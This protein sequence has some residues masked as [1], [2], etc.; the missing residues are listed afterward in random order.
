MRLNPFYLV[1]R[2]FLLAALFVGAACP[3]SAQTL[4]SLPG[5]VPQA[6]SR[7]TDV[8]DVPSTNRLSLALGLPVR[9]EPGLDKFLGELHDPASPNFRRYLTTEEFTARFG[10]TEKQYNEVIQFAR[11]HNLRVTGTHA[12]RLVLDVEGSAADVQR[13]F[14]ISLKNWQHPREGRKF[15]APVGEPVLDVGLPIARISGLDNYAMRRPKLVRKPQAVS[16]TV[17]P[18][19]GSSPNGSFMGYDFRKA[20]VPGTALTGAGQKVALLQFDTYYTNDVVAYEN[21]AGLPRVPLKNV[22]VNGGVSTPG[23]GNVEVCLDIEM[24]ISMAPGLDQVIVYIA[25]DITPW[26][27]ILSRIA[28]DNLAKQVSCSWGDTSPGSIDSSSE[29]ALKQMAAQGQ[30]FFNATGDDCAFT[31]SGIPFPSESTNV[32]Q[33]GGTTLTMSGSGNNYSSE[34]VWNWGGGTGSG[35]GVSINFS[36]PAWQQGT[37]NSTNLGSTSKRNVPDV[38]LTADDIFTISDNGTRS[39][40]GGTSAAAPLW[41][42]FMAL[43]NEQATLAGNPSAGNICPAVY[44]IGKGE[45][46]NYSY[47]DCFH[48]I[49][50]G[51][52]FWNSSPSKYPAVAGYD[53]CT[54]WGTPKGT[55][56]INALAGV[57]NTNLTPAGLVVSP[58]GG[59]VFQGLAKTIPTPDSAVFFLTNAGD[60]ALNWSLRSTSVWLRVNFTNGILAAHDSTNVT[61]SVTAKTTNLNVGLFTAKL[62]FTN[63]TARASQSVPV[64]FQ[65]DQPLFVTPTNPLVFTGLARGPFEPGSQMFTISN[66]AGTRV[67]WGIIKTSTWLTV[68][69]SAGTLVAGG[70]IN[71]S[72]NLAAS[73][74][75]LVSGKYFSQLVFTNKTSRGKFTVP[76]SLEVARLLV[77]SPTNG[78]AAI[79][80]VAGPFSVTTQDF[81]LSNAA[82]A[83]INWTLVNTCKWLV[84]SARTGPLNIGEQTNVTISLSTNANLLK[85]GFYRAT[86]S[87]TN[88]GSAVLRIPF[89]LSVGQSVVLNGGFEAGNFTNWTQSGNLTYTSVAKGT[90]AYV[91]AGVYG[92]K[93]GPSGEMGYLMQELATLMGQPYRVS[94]WIRNSTGGTPNRFTAKWGGDTI[95]D[96]SD[97]TSKAWTNFQFVVT[98]NDALTTLELGFEH[99]PNYWGLDDVTVVPITA[100]TASV[101]VAK[102]VAR[103]FVI[104]FE[105][106]P[107][108]KYQLQC[109]TD[110]AQPDWVNIGL[111]VTAISDTLE[112]ADPQAV[113]P[114]CFYRLKWVP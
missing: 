74:T 55:N 82:V 18:R 32:I 68:S 10:A 5:H 56:L 6:V 31:T 11:Q 95:L 51:N 102:R 58:A 69:A 15:F 9:D 75:N 52:N 81:A 78:F 13:A 84:A 87:V 111:P 48:D 2:L 67:N 90:N 8:G 61:V 14:Q 54:G 20:Y 92:A 47:T 46:P 65:M 21:L 7:L 106:T 42:G 79:G 53:L 101:R 99:A 33:V 34:T 16:N 49:K 1:A 64:L 97:I 83:A 86:I 57:V 44:A 110:L 100:P 63:R 12:S 77:V 105:V 71:I 76:V 103:A 59:F 73:A 50:T 85:A 4:K 23:S 35:G 80:A 24:A 45:N 88:K 26:A 30:S 19:A 60:A 3:A 17:A 114:V 89:T 41:A 39:D 28:N 37:I 94:F 72:V 93:M 27:T 38:A 108:L 109:K 104:N 98:A 96:T 25:P 70:S 40:S 107:G 62:F 22:A 43:V 36:I 66:Q 112:I 29:T 91:H 113:A